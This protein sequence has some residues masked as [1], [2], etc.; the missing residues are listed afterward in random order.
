MRSTQLSPGPYWTHV[1][2][3]WKSKEGLKVY[4]NRTLSTSDPSGKVAH[5]YGEPSGS[6]VMGPEQEQAQRHESRA[7]DEFIVWERALTPDE[8]AM[9]FTAAV[10][11]QRE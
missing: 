10:G 3:T 1:L 9:Y 4:V 6:L 7:F 2:F 11:L 5:A 8:I